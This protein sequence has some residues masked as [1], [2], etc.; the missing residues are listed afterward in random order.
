MSSLPEWFRSVAD[1]LEE[2]EKRPYG[3]VATAQDISV[4]G[5]ACIVLCGGDKDKA[6]SLWKQ[7]VADA[8]GYMPHIAAITLIR[9]TRTENLAPDVEAPVPS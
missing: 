4:A 7:I 2:A 6:R 1:A 3:P 9:A 5:G 8:G